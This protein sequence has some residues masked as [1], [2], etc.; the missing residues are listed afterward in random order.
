MNK[1]F[2][3]LIC[4][5]FPLQ[6]WGETTVQATVDRT[7]I[8]PDASLSLSVTVKDG[9]GE[10]DTSDIKDFDI[11]SQS[12]G[13]N[14]S[15]INGSMTR[16]KE[17]TYTLVPRSK[18][19]LTIPA[20]PV[21]TG[22]GLLHT[23]PIRITVTQGQ[24]S[25]A[26]SGSASIFL[27][28]SISSKKAYIGQQIIYTASVYQ[29]VNMADA[30]LGEPEFTGFSVD[31]LDDQKSFDTVINGQS[32]RVTQI[33]YVLTPLQS[34]TQT[35]GPATLSCDLMRQDRRRSRLDSFFSNDP[36]FSSG[37]RVHKTFRSP[38]LT[39]DIRDLPDRAPTDQP[40]SGLIGTFSIASKL[41]KTSLK[42]GES[43]TLTITISGTGNIAD[44]D[45]PVVTVP[46]DCKVYPD[47]PVTSSQTHSSGTTGQKNF[48]FALVPT[49]AG[50]LV[51]PPVTLNWFDP[52]TDSFATA[53][54]PSFTLTITQGTGQTASVR[55]H[56][57]T[58]P[59]TPP[60]PKNI[61]QDVTVLHR[62][63][64][65][66]YEDVDAVNNRAP[67][68]A[69]SF[70]AAMCIP[71]LLCGCVPL[72]KKRLRRSGHPSRRYAHKAARLIAEARKSQGSEACTLCSRA[73]I[74][75]VASRTHTLS[76][77][78]T[79]DEMH[80]LIIRTTGKND[81]AEQARALMLTLDT[82]R[83]GRSGIAPDQTKA[84]I[85]QTSKI[86]REL[87]A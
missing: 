39:V 18:G 46:D 35:I 34:G 13:S 75:S 67:L 79:Y 74:A 27:K 55:T 60:S 68:A 23:E 59:A 54:T 14:I 41:D 65:P 1:L 5:L 4:L 43:A 20:L 45:R 77:S 69:S 26:D 84:L 50:T 9:S 61:K 64:L 29:S 73:L 48:A 30:R 37:R 12:S 44:A 33:M 17:Y 25:T 86:V 47:E 16:T 78:L 83:Y 10:V 42:T 62:D 71:L 76:E 57:K 38:S 66:V 8:S 52:R 3:V 56:A 80:E 22:D 2:I 70:L 81:L 85:E 82:A 31:K 51:L 58:S 32:F 19:T 87:C 7:V 36:F 24:S 63:I 15:I 6:A 40:F 53:S 21:D 11:V 28:A 49:K 72:I